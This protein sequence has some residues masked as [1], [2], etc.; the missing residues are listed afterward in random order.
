MVNRYKKGEIFRADAILAIQQALS[1]AELIATLL[2]Y[3]IFQNN[4]DRD[5]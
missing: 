1:L 2:A 3:L 5:R 4:I